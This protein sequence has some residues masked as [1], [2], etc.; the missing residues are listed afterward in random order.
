MRLLFIPLLVFTL[1]AA[2]ETVPL[3]PGADKVRITNTTSDVLNCKAVGNLPGGT[4]NGLENQFAVIRNKTIGLG[5]NTVLLIP[6][7]EIA[8]VCP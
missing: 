5:G 2:C 7:S 6:G 4:V 8:Y 3:V 1:L